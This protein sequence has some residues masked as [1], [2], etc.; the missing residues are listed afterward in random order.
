[1]S[2]PLMSRLLLENGDISTKTPSGDSTA[3]PLIDWATEISQV[4][5][6]TP[7]MASEL[8]TQVQAFQKLTDPDN[9]T[10]RLLF[11]KITKAFDLKDIT[12]VTQELKIQALQA[13]LEDLRPS[14]RRKV[15]V[16]PNSKFADI[17]AIREA[18]IAA[19]RFSDDSEGEYDSEDS[20]NTQ[21]CINVVELSD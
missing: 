17:D 9:P 14:K 5:W 2:K 3:T 6:S 12:T 20:D 10:R 7:K 4:T 16:S 1:M 11:K 18:Q 8:R 21:D 13:Q 15:V 19:G